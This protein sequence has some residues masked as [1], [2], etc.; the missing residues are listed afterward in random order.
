MNTLWIAIR[1]RTREIGTLRAI[2]MQRARVLAMFLIEAFD[3][4]ALRRP[5]T[6]R[7]RGACASARCSTPRTCTRRW[8][9]Q[10]FLMREHLHLLV[11][12]SAVVGARR[13]HHRLAPCSSPSSP[14]S[15]PPG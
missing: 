10:L 15:S 4:R 6:G 12:P 14:P 13:A 8:R 11:E 9:V 2:G 5:L 3:A 7:G 1:E